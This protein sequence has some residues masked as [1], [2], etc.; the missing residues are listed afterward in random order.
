MTLLLYGLNCAPEPVGIGKHSGESA[1]WLTP[2]GNQVRVILRRP[3]SLLGACSL[4]IATA[5]EGYEP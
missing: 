1:V 3:T 4:A 5:V 2:Q